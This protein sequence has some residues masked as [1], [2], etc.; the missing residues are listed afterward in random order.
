MSS[1]DTFDE[2][3]TSANG[4]GFDLMVSEIAKKLARRQEKDNLVG[5]NILKEDVVSPTIMVSKLALEKEMHQDTLNRRLSLRPD[6]V[7]LKLRNILRI[8]S[9]EGLNKSNGNLDKS[10]NNFEKKANQL[11]SCLKKRPARAELEATNIVA[12]RRLSA[13]IAG[14]Q[15][16]LS[17]SMI[18]DVLETKIRNRPD[19]EEL[20]S[21]NILLIFDETVRVHPTFRK[22]EYNRKPD[23]DITY[24]RLTPQLKVAIRN[25]LNTFKQNEMDVHEDG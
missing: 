10:L 3:N 22:S 12:P 18:E 21:K 4:A 13:S 20:A 8:D 23:G 24:K 2:A 9:N 11:K 17:R 25:E 16:R 19:M 6:K 15:R 5:K 1:S 14:A 7:D